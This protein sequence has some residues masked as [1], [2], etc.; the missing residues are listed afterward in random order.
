MTDD[1]RR[2]FFELIRA[3]GEGGRTMELWDRIKDL[4][5]SVFKMHKEQDT[6]VITAENMTDEE[7]NIVRSAFFGEFLSL[8]SA[9]SCFKMSKPRALLSGMMVFR[10]EVVP[11]LLSVV[12]PAVHEKVYR[13]RS[14]P[15]LA[16][17]EELFRRKLGG[18][19]YYSKCPESSRD[20][21]HAPHKFPWWKEDFK[22]ESTDYGF[23]TT[24]VVTNYF[25]D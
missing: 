1:A 7:K 8:T 16:M 6:G 4:H 2:T 23:C 19:T 5:L 24:D 11:V 10:L 12:T 9:T 3:I 25:I 14:L 21:S 22:T 15:F 17:R 18:T 13:Q 20:D